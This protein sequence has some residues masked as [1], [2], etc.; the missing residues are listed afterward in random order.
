MGIIVDEQTTAYGT[1]KL[2]GL[3][4]RIEARLNREGTR[5]QSRFS[6]YA[7]REA[8]DLSNGNTVEVKLPS[9][10]NFE[11]SREKDGEDIL[12]FAHDKMV[13][14]LTTDKTEEDEVV[15]EKFTELKN[16]KVDI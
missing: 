8:Y 1:I 2:D 15:R 10:L 11:Y 14:W 3:Y 13:E 12:K 6:Y 4:I 5:I 9:Q 7:D 16:I